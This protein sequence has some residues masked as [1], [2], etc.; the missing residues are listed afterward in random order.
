M[1]QILPA[2]PKQSF[3]SIIGTGLGQALREGS[4]ER[5][6]REA[7]QAQEENKRRLLETE[8]KL[9][10]GLEQKKGLNPLQETQKNLAEERLKALQK[11]QDLFDKLTAGEKT[12]KESLIDQGQ[13]QESK[14]NI[15]KIP[16]EKLFEIAAFAG[17]P[18]QEGILGNIAKEELNRRKEAEQYEKD[19]SRKK[20][21]LGLT[22]DNE[23]LTQNDAFRT[24]LPSEEASLELMRDSLMTG[25]QSFFS[26]NNIAEKTGLEWFRDAAGGQF[27]TASKTF[28]INNVSKFGARPNQYIEQQMADALAKVGRSRSANMI[29]YNALKFDSN[30]KKQ[31]LNQ[32]DEISETDYKPGTLGRSIQEKMRS[33]VEN[34]QNNLNEKIRFI[35]QHEKEIDQVPKG[36]VPM[37]DNKGRLVYIPINE[38]DEAKFHGAIDL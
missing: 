31:F 33:F 18:G 29:T 30:I 3:G 26:P 13:S 35:K 32:S 15:K 28:L 9:K 2:N 16:S 5:M 38:I 11:Q 36:S 4:A 20:I 1:V 34:E 12:S 8:Y 7:L 6:Q 27:K 37:I 10:E 24:I 17:Q 14:F 22:R 21:E 23:I 25:D 19:I